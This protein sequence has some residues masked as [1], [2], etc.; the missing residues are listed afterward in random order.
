MSGI[1]AALA[2]DALATGVLP[3]GQSLRVARLTAGAVTAERLEFRFGLTAA[4][5]LELAWAELDV[6]GARPGLNRW[7]SRSTPRRSRPAWRS[8]GWPFPSWPG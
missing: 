8:K 1:E 5:V 3:P 4:R 6:L 2:S 7:P